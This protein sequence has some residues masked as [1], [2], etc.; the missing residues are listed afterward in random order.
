V[1]FDELTT[2]FYADESGFLRFQIFF[3]V[4]WIEDSNIG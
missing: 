3:Q 1:V 2:A 4:Y